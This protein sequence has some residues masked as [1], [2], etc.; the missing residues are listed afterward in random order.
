[1]LHETKAE[2]HQTQWVKDQKGE[3]PQDSATTQ[4]PQ[5]TIK[6]PPG[7]KLVRYEFVDSRLSAGFSYF[8]RGMRPGEVPETYKLVRYH[9]YAKSAPDSSDIIAIEEQPPIRAES[10]P[11]GPDPI[12]K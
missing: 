4:R 3:N 11:A 12:R 2:L 5:H 8:M 10:D 1:M 6:L 9:E 7:Q